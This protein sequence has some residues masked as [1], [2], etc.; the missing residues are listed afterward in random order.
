MNVLALFALIWAG[1]DSRTDPVKLQSDLKAD[2][3]KLW[4]AE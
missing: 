1:S 3:E 4:A 2:V